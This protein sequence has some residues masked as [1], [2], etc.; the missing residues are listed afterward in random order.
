MSKSLLY[1]EMLEMQLSVLAI[2]ESLRFVLKVRNAG[3]QH[4]QSRRVPLDHVAIGQPGTWKLNMDFELEFSKTITRDMNPE[5]IPI[6][7]F[8]FP[9]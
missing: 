3:R 9:L 2:P 4:S 5:V 1:R 8:A 7:T 6:V